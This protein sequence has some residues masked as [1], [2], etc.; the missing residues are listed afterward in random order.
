MIV[1]FDF[2]GTVAHSFPWFLSRI[3]QAAKILRFNEVKEEDVELL[4]GMSTN[5]ILKFL[6]ISSIKLPFVIF[7]FK[8]LMNKESQE[9]K[10]F[11][12]VPELFKCLKEKKVKT[13]IL[14][15]NSVK[16]VTQILGETS[17]YVSEYYCGAGLRTKEKYFKKIKN[18][19]PMG[20]LLSVGDEPRDWL[21]AQKS[22]ITH[23][24]VG[25]GYASKEAFID[26]EVIESF[27]ELKTRIFRYFNIES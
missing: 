4:R 23:L 9:I 16:N 2:D 19:Y 6:N 14:S 26:S 11:H 5:E 1:I 12:E 25:W 13:I 15:S 24:N 22:G 17:L 18:K 21:A 27:E 3:N 20:Q 10:L 7:Y 8:W